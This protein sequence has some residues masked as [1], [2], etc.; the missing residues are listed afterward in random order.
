MNDI[1]RESRQRNRRI[2]RNEEV[3]WLGSDI[4]L[5]VW[6]VIAI[7]FIILLGWVWMRH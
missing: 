4:R 6:A 2:A 7:V 5:S 3:R 1:E